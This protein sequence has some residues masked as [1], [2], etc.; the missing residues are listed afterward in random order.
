MTGDDAYAQAHSGQRPVSYI[1]SLSQM[2][3]G[4]CCVH[5]ACA[6]TPILKRIHSPADQKRN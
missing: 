3:A 5:G 2:L 4:V 1:G 6:L